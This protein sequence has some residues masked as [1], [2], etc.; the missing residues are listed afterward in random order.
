MEGHFDKELWGL[1]SSKKSN[2]FFTVG[3]DK[4]LLKW[5]M[6]KRKLTGK[7]KLPFEAMSVDVNRDSSIVA[8]GMRNGIVMFYDYVSLKEVGKKIVNYKNPDKEV[9]SLVKYSPDSSIIAVAYCPPVSK[10]LLYDTKTYK[11]VG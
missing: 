8:V 6:P 11:K 5:D 3:Q 9:L 1:A 7:L 4:L 10:V 2:E